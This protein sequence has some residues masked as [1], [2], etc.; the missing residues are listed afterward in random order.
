[1][2]QRLQRLIADQNKLNILMACLA[3][4]PLTRNIVLDV[5][6][7][8]VLRF[9]ARRSMQSLLWISLF[10]I[11][12]VGVGQYYF[13]LFYFG[14]SIL[15][16]YIISSVLG[17]NNNWQRTVEGF[18]LALVALCFVI[19]Y[20]IPIEWF[21]FLMLPFIK[22]WQGLSEQWFQGQT[23]LSTEQV[24]QLLPAFMCVYIF[25]NI[26]HVFIG[27][28]LQSWCFNPGGF[29]QELRAF[30]LSWVTL[31]VLAFGIVGTLYQAPFAMLGIMLAI[32]PLALLG[33]MKCFI[34]F[35]RV[36]LKAW[37]LPLIA[38]AVIFTMPYSLFALVLTGLFDTILKYMGVSY[39]SYF[40]RKSS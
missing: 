21:N 17:Q 33:F 2:R 25:S 7:L 40:A 36:R 38:I 30:S 11:I 8:R 13:A 4:L 28:A 26:V 22:Q 27:R 31:A 10:P 15:P 39:A 1:M 20:V 19:Q 34:G 16:I 32:L 23:I 9:G 37:M 5:L 29:K 24:K 12:M 6:A 14:F 35:E 3:A 18:M